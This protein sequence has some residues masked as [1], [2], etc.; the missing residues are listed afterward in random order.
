MRSTVVNSTIV[1]C[2]Q[3]ST[4]FH[5]SD[6]FRFVELLGHSAVV[7]YRS[8]VSYVRRTLYYLNIFLCLPIVSRSSCDGHRARAFMSTRDRPVP[9]RYRSVSSGTASARHCRS[10]REV[11]RDR[12]DTCGRCVCVCCRGGR[13]STTACGTPNGPCRR[14]V[15]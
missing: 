2:E 15:P 5:R 10:T 9:S 8:L 6:G 11:P 1:V 12:R 3:N 7:P 14:D 4:N 13:V